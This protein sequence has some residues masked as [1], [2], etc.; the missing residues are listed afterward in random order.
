MHTAIKHPVPDRGKPSFV[1]FLHPGT[2]TLTLG[3]NGLITPQDEE[4][5]NL[6]Y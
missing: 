6:Y 1:I 2:L 3:V 5:I 4:L